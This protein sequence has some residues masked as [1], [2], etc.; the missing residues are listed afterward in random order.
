M[1]V[2]MEITPTMSQGLRPPA[3]DRSGVHPESMVAASA[4]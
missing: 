2:A 3:T 4:I 1:N